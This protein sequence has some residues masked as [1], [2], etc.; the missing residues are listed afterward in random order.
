MFR[1]RLQNLI[2]PLHTRYEK[3]LKMQLEPI[4]K[5]MHPQYAKHTGRQQRVLEDLR[6]PTICSTSIYL[7]PRYASIVR[8]SLSTAASQYTPCVMRALR[9]ANNLFCTTLSWSFLPV[10]GLIAGGLANSRSRPTPGA[11]RNISLNFVHLHIP[12]REDSRLPAVGQCF[13]SLHDASLRTQDSFG[14]CPTGTSSRDCLWMLT[15]S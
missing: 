1:E 2:K 6:M 5:I 10:Y 8:R 3:R 12:K 9:Q 15:S 7:A 14:Y 4:S 13:M 11:L